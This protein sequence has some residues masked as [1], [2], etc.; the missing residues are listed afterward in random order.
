MLRQ[1]SLLRAG[2]VVS[3]K[4]FEVG[5]HL[6]RMHQDDARLIVLHVSKASKTY[7]PQHLTATHLQHE[8]NT[9]F[10]AERVPDA[11]LVQW[12]LRGT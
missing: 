3:K 7:L 11:G 4:A 5:L 10:I 12:L 8:Y 1:E 9:A 2:S 6:K